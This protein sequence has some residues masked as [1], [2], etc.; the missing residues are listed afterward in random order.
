M[1]QI[2]RL[3][4]SLLFFPV[5]FLLNSCLGLDMNIALN[6]NGSGTISLEYRISKSLDSLGKLDGNERWNTIPAG[7][8][9]FERTLSRLPEIK[10]ISF[11]S[12]EDQRDVII[13]AKLAFSD[14]NGLL[15]FL[16]ASGRRS[17][18][19]GNAGS[20]RLLITLSGGAKN[21]D[22]NLL[23]LIEEISASYSIKMSM[24]FPGEGDLAVLDNTGKALETQKR[25]KTVSCSF[26]LYDVLSSAN[27]INA[28]FKW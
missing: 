18:F 7:R 27:G 21:N 3:K 6:Q 12:K 1:K 8:A 14:I 16:D 26:P 20:G 19:S 15:A 25:G 9:D 11:S 28:E 13:S 2:N 10:L 24:S 17:S 23:K 5:L 4:L 22:A